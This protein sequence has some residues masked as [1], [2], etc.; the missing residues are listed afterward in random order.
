MDEEE[1]LSPYE[2]DARDYAGNEVANQIGVASDPEFN[3][4]DVPV[5]QSITCARCGSRGT[6]ASCGACGLRICCECIA[7]AD[8]PGRDDK[9][10]VTCRICHFLGPPNWVETLRYHDIL[11]CGVKLNVDELAEI[12]LNCE[13]CEVTRPTNCC[14]R[15]HKAL[16]TWCAT[17]FTPPHVLSAIGR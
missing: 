6:V 7:S 5:K 14:A 12:P 15:C 4:D 10:G 1:P 11:P 9:S 17:A 8:H 16:C 13:D 2:E 3:N